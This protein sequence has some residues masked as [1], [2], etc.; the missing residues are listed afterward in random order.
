MNNYIPLLC[1]LVFLFCAV[2]L[3]KTT[4]TW[5]VAKCLT[6]TAGPGAEARGPLGLGGAAWQAGHAQGGALRDS[7]NA[8]SLRGSPVATALPHS[9]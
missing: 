6:V 8:L 3:G 2:Y 4:V 1:R 9:P 7:F 5:Y